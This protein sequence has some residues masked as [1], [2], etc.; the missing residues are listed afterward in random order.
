MEEARKEYS[1]LVGQRK[2][3][4][5]EEKKIKEENKKLQTEIDNLERSIYSRR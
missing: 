4:E 2:V 1:R 5:E 3:F